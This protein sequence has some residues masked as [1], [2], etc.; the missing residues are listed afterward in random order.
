MTDTTAKILTKG[1]ESTGLTEE[2]ANDLF[3]KVGSHFMAIVEL[4]VVY[5]HGPNTDGKRRIDLRLKQ[6]EPAMDANLADHLREL[7]RTLYFNRQVDQPLNSGDE[8]SVDQVLAAGRKHEPHPYLAS[9]LSTDDDAICD[10]CGQVE[11]VP[12]HADRSA[13]DDPFTVTEEDLDT[14]DEDED[15]DEAACDDSDDDPDD[16]DYGDTLELEDQEPVTT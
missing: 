13:L 8:P 16:L 3:R 11:G 15:E 4:E 12:V 9:T 7:T 10:V 5:P 2:I 1:C 6:V 14:A